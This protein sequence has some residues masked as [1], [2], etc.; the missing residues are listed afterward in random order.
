MFNCTETL[1]LTDDEMAIIRDRA[2]PLAPRDRG[3][4]LRE[5]ATELENHEMLGPGLVARVCARLQR[6]Y[7]F[8]ARLS[9]ER[10]PGAIQGG[11]VL[12]ALI[13]GIS[14]R[15]ALPAVNLGV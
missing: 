7:Y 15:T 5:V 6:Q 3:E 11:R 10:P 13:G 14:G 1:V 12:T 4:F 9:L 8:P 2:T